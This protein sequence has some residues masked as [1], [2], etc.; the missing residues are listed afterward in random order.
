[1][2]ILHQYGVTERWLRSSCF[3]IISLSWM[4]NLHL[5]RMTER[6]AVDSDLVKGY[7]SNVSKYFSI[8]LSSVLIAFIALGPAWP[9]PTWDPDPVVMD[10]AVTDGLNQDIDTVSFV[11]FQRVYEPSNHGSS[12]CQGLPGY[13]RTTIDLYAVLCDLRL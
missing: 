1:V 12:V 8:A 3:S 7:A 2:Q 11:D 10:A 6:P 9:D 5:T 13:N 4:P